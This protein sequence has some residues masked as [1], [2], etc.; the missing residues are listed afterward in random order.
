MFS[1]KPISRVLVLDKLTTDFMWWAPRCLKAAPRWTISRAFLGH[2]QENTA[3]SR[4]RTPIKIERTQPQPNHRFHELSGLSAALFTLRHEPLELFEAEILIHIASLF[5][6]FDQITSSCILSS[7][8]GI[9]AS[10]RL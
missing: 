4:F 5:L 7:S 6:Y 10:M 9:A 1:P 8:M 2:R 3:L